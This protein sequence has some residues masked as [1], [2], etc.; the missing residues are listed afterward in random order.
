MPKL[1]FSLRGVPEDEAEEVRILLTENNIDYYETSAGNWGISMPALWVNHEH[2]WFKA[3]ALLNN[4]QQQRFLSQRSHYER[5]KKEGRNTQLIDVFCE[6]PFK[7]IFYVS[8]IVFILYISF[9]LLIDMG[10]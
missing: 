3:T 8:F 5:Q 2:D 4:Y 6:K 1:L 9:K 10:L 7:F